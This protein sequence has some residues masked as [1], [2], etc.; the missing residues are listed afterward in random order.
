MS[1]FFLPS[2]IRQEE[3]VEISFDAYTDG[4]P[5]YLIFFLYLYSCKQE[6]EGYRLRCTNFAVVKKVRNTCV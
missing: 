2:F 5:G 1:F 3:E 6:R 4:R